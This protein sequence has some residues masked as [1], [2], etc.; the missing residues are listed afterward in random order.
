MINIYSDDHQSALK[1]LED[2]EVNI[3]NVLIMVDN[4]NIRNSNWNPFY[5]F[6]SFHSDSL[7]NVT[8]SFNLKLSHTN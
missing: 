7:L 8:D 5:P 4:F 6:H 2:T 3:H 1:Y